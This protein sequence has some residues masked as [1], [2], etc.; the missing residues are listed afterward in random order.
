MTLNAFGLQMC[1]LGILNKGS[2][3]FLCKFE[4]EINS[5]DSVM[6]V[7]CHLY[8]GIYYP[9]S[10]FSLLNVIMKLCF[11][12]SHLIKIFQIRHKVH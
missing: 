3:C 9:L 7:L 5:V 11:L 10:S 6:V 8:W 1:N 12:F 2:N 4:A